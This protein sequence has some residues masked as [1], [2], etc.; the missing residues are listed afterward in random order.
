MNNMSRIFITGSSD[1]IGQAGA[2]LLADQGHKVFLHARNPCR[3]KQAH[4]AVAKAEGVIIGYL[5]TIEGSKALA[6]EAD[7]SGPWD[8]VIHNAGLGPSNSDNKTSDGFQSTFAVNSLGPYILTALMEKPKRLLYLSSQLHSGGSDDLDDITWSK[9]K[10]QSMQAYSYSKLHDVMIANAVARYWPD[11]QSC[12]L[13]PGWIKTKM[14]GGGAPGVVGTPA[15][16]LADYAIGSSSIVGDKTGAYFNPQGARTPHKG[17][18]ST[19]KQ[20]EFMSICEQLSGVK[21]PK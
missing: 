1:G 9:R 7:N 2:K 4:E 11:V 14:G 10:F 13:D 17:A 16:A 12:S 15:K 21:F 18:T 3:A 19:Q 5:T 8:T 6:A 20:D